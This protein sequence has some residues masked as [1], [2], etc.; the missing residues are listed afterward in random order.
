M[1][2]LRKFLSPLGCLCSIFSPNEPNG[3]DLGS[4]S[5]ALSAMEPIRSG[6]AGH[7]LKMVY[8]SACSTKRVAS[9][10]WELLMVQMGELRL[11]VRNLG[12][13]HY[14]SGD[15]FQESKVSPLGPLHITTVTANPSLSKSD[16]PPYCY[17]GR[18]S[19]HPSC[20]ELRCISASPTLFCFLW[21]LLF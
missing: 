21:S 3:G 5:F 15:G 19:G 20:S 13:N 9:Q 11:G 2:L 17:C 6:R 12:R 4:N 7:L 16:R 14:T 8:S 18:S 1:Y 10:T